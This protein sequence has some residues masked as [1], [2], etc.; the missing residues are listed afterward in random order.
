MRAFAQTYSRSS[1]SPPLGSWIWAV[2]PDTSGRHSKPDNPLTLLGSRPIAHTQARPQKSLIKRFMPILS[3]GPATRNPPRLPDRSRSSTNTI[4]TRPGALACPHTADHP[5]EMTS[6]G[7]THPSR[8][9]QPAPP[10]SCGAPDNRTGARGTD[11]TPH[12]WIEV[13]NPRL[14]TTTMA[15]QSLLYEGLAALGA[16][17]VGVSDPLYDRIRVFPYRRAGHAL[18]PRR[19][20][21]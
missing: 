1:P 15:G 12:R 18:D 14:L 20:S 10:Q 21:R 16:E 9:P 11:I 8:R 2:R 5:A 13:K 17:T 19:P 4:D 3:P 6:T 7:P